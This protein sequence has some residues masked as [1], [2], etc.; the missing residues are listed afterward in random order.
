MK[1]QIIVWWTASYIIISH[2]S[3]ISRRW[4]PVCRD[5]VFTV[6]GT[7]EDGV[8]LTSPPDKLALDATTSEY[9]TQTL[10]SSAIS[11]PQKIYG[12]YCEPLIGAPKKTLAILAHGLTYDHTYWNGLLSNPNG[13]SANSMVTYLSNLGYSTLSIDRLGVGRSD[14][15][16]PVNIVQIPYQRELYRNLITQLRGGSRLPIPTNWPKILWIGHSMGSM[17]GASIAVKDPTAIDGLVLTGIAQRRPTQNEVGIFGNNWVQANTYDRRRFPLPAYSRGYY[18]T[19]SKAGRQSTFYSGPSDFFSF[20]YDLDF[21]D[22]DAVAIGE[23]LTEGILVAQGY[24]NPLY[25][26]TGD[27]DAVFCGTGSRALGV[28]N[29]GSGR[30]SQVAALKDFFPAVP[31]AKFGSYV[32]RNAGHALQMHYTAL[33]GFNNLKIFLDQQGF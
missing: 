17:I 19:S 2:A 18:V 15:P 25:I 14:H 4:I 5:V 23:I 9:F 33:E 20:I 32:Q 31:A 21:N 1:K 8:K 11:G 13:L 6:T 26:T 24:K 10:V 16:D 7:A 22:K 29:C 30:L 12:Q 27:Q 3:S 28:P